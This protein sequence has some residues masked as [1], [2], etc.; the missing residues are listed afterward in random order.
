[1]IIIPGGSISWRCCMAV[2][3][4]SGNIFWAISVK[5]E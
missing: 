1:M 2:R 4:M 5:P 3:N